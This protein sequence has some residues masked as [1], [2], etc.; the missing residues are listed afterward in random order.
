[1]LSCFEYNSP[2]LPDGCTFRIS[3]SQIGKFFSFPSVWYEEQILGNSQFHASTATVLGTIIHACAEMYAKGEPI[4]RADIDAY[5]Q[6]VVANHPVTDPAIDVATVKALYPDMAAL[7]INEYLRHNRPTVVEEY[8][9]AEVQNGIYI[10]GSCDNRTRDMVVDYKN[11]SQKPNTDK[12]PFDYFIQLMGY[13]YAY[14]ANGIK[15]NRIRIVY[16]VRPT[17]TLPVRI[18]PVTHEITQEDWEKIE[19]TLNLI[20]ETV[21]TVR[22]NP[23]LTHL[24][25]K[26]YRLKET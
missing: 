22:S 2:P 23:E 17:K 13:A 8:V 12:I 11:V 15:I 18:F 4:T 1:M 24:L 16:T 10:Q 25:F 5:L 20:A 7:L 6:N 9:S 26:S 14:R 19:D 3:P 21:L